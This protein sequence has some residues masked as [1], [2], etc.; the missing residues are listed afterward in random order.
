[1][2]LVPGPVDYT[3]LVQATPVGLL[4]GRGPGMA[5]CMAWG[6]PRAGAGLLVGVA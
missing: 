5:G 3:A 4:L 6:L 1:M 2:G